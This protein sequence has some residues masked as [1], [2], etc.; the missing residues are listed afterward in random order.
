MTLLSDIVGAFDEAAEQHGVEKVRTIG[1][2]Y[3]AASGLSLERPDHTARMVEFAREAAR[4]VRR[5]NAERQTNLIAEIRINAGPVIGGL[6]GR[7]KFIYDLW[8]DTVR[9][10]RDIEPTGRPRS[11]SPGRSTIA[12]A[13]RCRSARRARRHPG[14]WHDRSLPGARGGGRM[15]EL[16]GLAR[17]VRRLGAGA[18]GRPAARAHRRQRAGVRARPRAAARP[19][20][21]CGRTRI[22]VL[23]AVAGVFFLRACSGCPATTSGSASLTMSTGSASSSWRWAPPTPSSSSGRCRGSWQQR[24]PKLLRDLVRLLLVAI[25]GALV[26]SFVWGREIRAR[27]PPSA[28]RRS[29]SAWRCRSR[30]AT[31]SRA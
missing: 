15:N 24:V 26:Y 11:S 14:P 16:L 7:R 27:S 29:S 30:S 20:P 19:R 25:A 4:I 1:S 3:L 8:G 9:L 31:S 6:V 10:A 12:C 13:S 18:R 21:G 23:P 17:G 5:F 28:S 2:S 22:W